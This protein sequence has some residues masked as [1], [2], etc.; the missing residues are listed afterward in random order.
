M[1]EA[2]GWETVYLSPPKDPRL[3]VWVMRKDVREEIE[4]WATNL[5]ER[6]NI[7]AIETL[8]PFN[9]ELA[10]DDRGFGWDLSVGI[11]EKV[12]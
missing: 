3:G 12:A 2:D 7:V 8:A 1:I 11:W 6:L 9:V 5:P 4:G 10:R